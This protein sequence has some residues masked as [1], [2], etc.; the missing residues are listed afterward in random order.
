VPGSATTSATL[1][2]DP[3]GGL[4][5]TGDLSVLGKLTVSG[6]I[7]GTLATQ[8]TTTTTSSS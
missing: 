3:A 7:N 6:G 2:A 5:I 8:T 1:T 4:K